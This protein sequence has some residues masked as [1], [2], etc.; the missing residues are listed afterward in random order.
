MEGLIGGFATT[1]RVSHSTLFPT[2][3]IVQGSTALEI[4]TV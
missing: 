2:P 1:R 3:H 4:N